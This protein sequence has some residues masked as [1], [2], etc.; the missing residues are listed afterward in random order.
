MKATSMEELLANY[1][2]KFKTFKR[3][4][5]VEAKLLDLGKNLAIFDIGG[6]AE[7]IVNDIYFNEAKDYLKTMK[8]GDTVMANVMNPES[9]DGRVILS[10]RNAANDSI[11]DRLEKL[12]KE[13]NIISVKITGVSGNGVTASFEGVDGY[14]PQNNLGKTISSDLDSLIEKHL[15]V[16][17]TEVDRSKKR[18]VF[19]E[20]AV[21]EAEDIALHQKALKEV[22]EGQIYE[23][24][25][26][27]NTTFGSFVEINVK[28][29]NGETP[30]EGL[31]HVSELSWEKVKN[32]DSAVKVGDKLQVKVLGLREG[33]LALSVKQAMA[34]PWDKIEEKYKKDDKV[35]GTVTRTSDYGVFVQ[36]EPGIE[37][38]IHITKI[39]PGTKLEKGQ[40][41]SVY[42]EEVDKDN[43]KISLGMVL[44]AKPVNYR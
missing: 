3:G 1:G 12:R 27:Q 16:K 44:T 37:G 17:I 8:V 6:K 10:L 36:L 40:E 35:K 33:K 2:S 19:S 42:V 13:D 38:L 9:S 22:K 4:E 25:V 28:T 29:D 26:T 11:W 41:V 34:D 14:I 18:V 15:E 30:I 20:K 31:V 32:P 23:G 39:A 43:H 7:A 5:K 24:T 21:S